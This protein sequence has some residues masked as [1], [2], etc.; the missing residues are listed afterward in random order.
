MPESILCL[1]CEEP[2]T[3]DDSA[4]DYCNECAEYFAN[5]DAQFESEYAESLDSTLNDEQEN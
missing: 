5:E 2:L 1:G 4:P 3:E